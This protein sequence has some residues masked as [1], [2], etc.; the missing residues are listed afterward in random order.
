M[1]RTPVFRSTRS[2]GCTRGACAATN[3]AFSRPVPRKARHVPD[4]TESSAAPARN[5]IAVRPDPQRQD[6]RG[7]SVPCRCHYDHVIVLVTGKVIDLLLCL[8]C[9]QGRG[10][11]PSVPH[12]L[13]LPRRG[14]GPS[15]AVRPDRDREIRQRVLRPSTQ[16]IPWCQ[17][18]SC[19]RTVCPSAMSC[20]AKGLRFV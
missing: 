13:P 4:P 19:P 5:T 15:T 20:R 10:G 18:H 12:R 7:V 17:C 16:Q 8:G 11:S 2:G 3:P 6:R 1:T 14:E 9:P